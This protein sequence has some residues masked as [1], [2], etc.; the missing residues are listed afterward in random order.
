MT[1]FC[2]RPRFYLMRASAQLAVIVLSWCVASVA[3]AQDNNVEDCATTN[4][5]AEKCGPQDIIDIVPKFDLDW[6]PLDAV[7]E[8]L[9]DRQCMNC[10]GRYIDPLPPPAPGSATTANNEEIHA[11]AES[12]SLHGDDVLLLGEANAV[13]G[14]RHMRSDKVLVNRAKGMATLTDNVTLREPDVLVQGNSAKIFYNSNEAVIFDS[15][16]VLHDQHMHGTA[17]MLVQDE[18]GLI[19]THNGD[20]TYCAPENNDWAVLSKDAEIDLDE[21]LATLHQATIEVKDTPVFYSPWLRFPL[22]D[23]RRTGLLWPDFGN[24]SNGGL[25]ISTPIYLNLAPNYDALYAPRYIEQRG[26]DHE[27]Q[28]RYL[29]PLVGQ[30]IAG[31]AYLEEDKKYRDEVSDQTSS[32][33]WLGT[34]KQDGLFDGRW[35]SHIDYSQ[36]SD[37]DYMK[38]LQTANIDVQRSTSLLQLVSMD[39]LGDNWLVDLR[40]QKFQS[41]ANDIQL[42]YEELP[43]ITGQYRSSSMPFELHPIALAQY[44]N[45]G[46]QENIVTGER[47]YGET[48]LSYPMLWR[49]GGLTPTVKYRQIA[50]E[51]NEATLPIDTKPSAGA[52][53]FDLDGNLVFERET[54]FGDKPL[55]Q[56][57]EPRLY[58]LY[59]SRENQSDQPLFDTAQLT[60]DYHQLFRD[61]RFSGHDRLDDANQI[62][63]GV[64]TRLVDDETGRDLGHASIGQIYY[65]ANPDVHLNGYAAP[66]DGSNSEIAGEVG[67]TPSKNF[68]VGTSVVWDP[69]RAQWN[70]AFLQSSYKAGNGS[71]FN[72]GYAYRRA[73]T[74]Y[75]AQPQTDEIS[76]SSYLPLDNKWS[77]FGAIAY[78]IQDSLSVEDMIGVE[79]DTCCWTARVMN[80][81]YYNNVNGL[82][83]DF[84]NPNLQR[85]S[86]LQF[87]ILLKGMGGFGNR[88]TNV[89][90]RMIR[91]FEEREY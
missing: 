54:S 88:I 15:R 84:S 44:T 17:D 23:R 45:F 90:Q 2:A 76:V 57:L 82:Q 5:T 19:H 49:S 74:T 50:Y 55:L 24:N 53:L 28:L 26:L 83:P 42:N 41:L 6:V 30:W 47:L 11:R 52:P 25:D 79:Y 13:Q 87:Q 65:F 66:T 78:S 70:A 35:R 20:V 67:I 63:A 38:D 64:T 61:T 91:G 43:Q 72:L 85:Q 56:T 36:A 33:R 77:I 81:R 46:A 10:G 80:L 18:D 68:L 48:G 40:S 29:N 27:L 60:F 58:Y 3:P 32:D 31:G 34:L 73:A 51:L 9:R 75:L 62:S 39:Y 8:G 16:F 4:Y 86:T 89:M 71:I 37:I 1:L 69:N 21:G 14:D 22:D 12:S 7:P 59:S